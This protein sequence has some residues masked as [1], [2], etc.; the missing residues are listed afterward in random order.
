MAESRESFEALAEANL[1][2]LYNLAVRLA[3]RPEEAEDLVQE[4]LLRAFRFYDS[5]E[6]GTNFKAWLFKILKNSFINRYRKEQLEPDMVHFGAIEE[7]LERIVDST[8]GGS[9]SPPPDPERLFMDGLVDDE[10]EAAIRELPPE[11]RMVLIMAVVEEM[12][13]KEIAAA[14]SCPIGTVMSRLHRAR[15]LMQSRLLEY[16]RRHGLA[17]SDES[18]P[19]VVDITR[20]RGRKP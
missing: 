18:D 19:G 2:P 20:F 17:G 12:S 16:A 1:R 11:Y 5:F 3:R 15:R 8:L 14:I 7:G 9:Q 10:I 6:P 4:T 13:Y